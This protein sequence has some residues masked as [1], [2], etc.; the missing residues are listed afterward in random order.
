MIHNIKK[1]SLIT[2]TLFLGACST[3]PSVS[4]IEEVKGDT[5]ESAPSPKKRP[6][7]PVDSSV[8]ST[9][10]VRSLL[11]NAQIHE[12]NGEVITAIALLERAIRIAPRYPES[13]LRLAE[14]KFQ[15]QDYNQAKSL[16]QK[17]LSLGA[18]DDIK[19][20]AQQLLLKIK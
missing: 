3:A 1:I 6:I 11:D 15:Q 2:L 13:Y 16:S 4:E 12:R 8:K 18:S 7:A 9:P 19:K 20:Q 17:A 5:I 14:I 10:I